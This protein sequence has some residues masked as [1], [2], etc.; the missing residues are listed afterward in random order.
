MS[1]KI[2]YVTKS[3]SIMGTSFHN[4]LYI[5]YEKV[6]NVSSDVYITVPVEV[7]GLIN[8]EK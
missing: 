4:I 3:D 2:G 1:N 7:P 5:T 8:F 6:S